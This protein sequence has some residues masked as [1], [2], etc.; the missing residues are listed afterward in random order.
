MNKYLMESEKKLLELY[1]CSTIRE[2]LKKQKKILH[3]IE[4]NGRNK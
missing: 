1:S 2:V 4:K 3:E